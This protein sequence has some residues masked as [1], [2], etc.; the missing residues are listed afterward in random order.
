M[1]GG[2][3]NR[4]VAKSVLAAFVAAW[5]G[6]ADHSW[7]H[8]HDQGV[9]CSGGTLLECGGCDST[10]HHHHT[11]LDP[12]H[13]ACRVCAAAAVG[14]L[15]SVPKLEIRLVAIRA[16]EPAEPVSSEDPPLTRSP[17]RGPPLV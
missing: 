3:G 13:M 9:E 10:S 8:S 5:I 16:A 4:W 15:P 11:P 6:S 1:V 7:G 14:Q 12:E 2:L 17:N